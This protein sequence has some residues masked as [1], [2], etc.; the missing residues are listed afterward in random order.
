MQ[1]CN[2]RWK[3]ADGI[4]VEK[5]IVV[6][7]ELKLGGKLGSNKEPRRVREVAKPLDS[8]YKRLRDGS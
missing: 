5:H 6:Q 3:G 2:G 4:K 1:H 8:W 7:M